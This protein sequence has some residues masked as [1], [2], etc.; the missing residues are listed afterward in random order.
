MLNLSA[1]YTFGIPS[2]IY[3][4]FK[5]KLG[6]HGLWMGLTFSLIYCAVIGTWICIRTDWNREVQKVQNRLKEEDKKRRV[7][8]EA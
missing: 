8:S 1:Y 7:D 2:G 5:L 6:L 4:A 3:F